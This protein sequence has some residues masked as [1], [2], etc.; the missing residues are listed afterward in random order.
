MALTFRMET[1]CAYIS[2]S[3]ATNGCSLRWLFPARRVSF[4]S[5]SGNSRTARRT[6]GRY[7]AGSSAN[8][9]LSSFR[10]RAGLLRVMDFMGFGVLGSPSFL[11]L[12]AE[13]PATYP[14]APAAPLT[15]KAAIPLRGQCPPRL[16]R[17]RTSWSNPVV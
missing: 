9:A 17:I 12:F 14:R 3:A 4:V 10:L 6:N 8:W 2:T 11:P 15:A 1:P 5:A 16:G 13:L 7:R